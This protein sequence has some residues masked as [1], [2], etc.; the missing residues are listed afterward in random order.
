MSDTA[1]STLG[2][3]LVATYET[4]WT[5]RD[6]VLPHMIDY[7]LAHQV[8]AAARGIVPKLMAARLCAPLRK[9]RHIKAD[10]LPFD[11]RL[12]GLHPCLEARIRKD[13][14]ADIADWL[15]AGRARQEIEMVARL[16]AARS[17]LM[18]ALRTHCAYRASLLDIA[19]RECETVIP[20]QTWAQPAEVATAGYIFEAS[21]LAAADDFARLNAGLDRLN[22]SRADIGQIV[23]PPMPMDR[24]RV[25]GFLG[26]TTGGFPSSLRA[27][28]AADT[29]CAVIGDLAVAA[30]NIARIAETLYL[31]C[32]A[33]FGLARFGDSFTG[34][35]H[36]M[37]QKRNPY[38]LREVRPM[39][40]RIAG[41]YQDALHLFTGGAPGIGN[42]V[43]HIPN[44][45][46]ACADDMALIS[47]CLA[48]ALKTVTFDRRR[49]LAALRGTWCQA[50]QLVFTLVSEAGIP[51]RS[52]HTLVAALVKRLAAQN[53]EPET[54]DVSDIATAAET[55]IGQ[56]VSLNAETLRTVMDPRAIVDSRANGGPAPTDVRRRLDD[57]RKRLADDIA[58]LDEM[59]SRIDAGKDELDAAIMALSS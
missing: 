43:V 17:A 30:G 15:N 16:L 55:S 29:E 10:D 57:A 59:Q 48:D 5:H 4:E 1:G 36:I 26:L 25:A 9:L 14:G 13:E 20:W 24:D 35:S 49:G 32:S 37:P 50:P 28:A 33:E 31:W 51:F 11:A 8:A 41:R 19:E 21:A 2:D 22:R 42:G 45:T 12:D 53:R 23:P 44:R 6:R 27:Y 18:G 40:T 39:F 56:K 46:I 38:A 58:S 47:D 34:T 52:A 3:S 7:H 54:V